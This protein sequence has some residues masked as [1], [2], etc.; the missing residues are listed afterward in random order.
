MHLLLPNELLLCILRCMG[1]WMNQP[2][3]CCMVWRGLVRLLPRR[4]LCGCHPHWQG[5]HSLTLPPASVLES[6]RWSMFVVGHTV[7]RWPGASL[8][9]F[10]CWDRVTDL[11]FTWLDEHVVALLRRLLP[12]GTVSALCFRN[13]YATAVVHTQLAAVFTGARLKRLE[14]SNTLLDPG[15]TQ[16]D[17]EPTATI[18]AAVVGLVDLKLGETP[19]WYPVDPGRQGLNPILSTT[20][21]LLGLRRLTV[22][23]TIWWEVWVV[24]EAVVD[25]PSREDDLSHQQEVL[26]SLRAASRGPLGKS[27]EELTLIRGEFDTPGELNKVIASFSLAKLV[28]KWC[29][30]LDTAITGL[31]HPKTAVDIQLTTPLE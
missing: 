11:S 26:D 13:I 30:L 31:T 18:I 29:R 24:M 5:A 3:A 16:E 15:S 27:L 25:A 20:L 17:W 28:L 19:I 7:E 1:F 6:G 22:H 21:P 4:L 9:S 12:R 2:A 23:L 14:L 10:P 8:A